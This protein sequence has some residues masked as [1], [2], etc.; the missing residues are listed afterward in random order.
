MHKNV[1]FYYL[2]IMQEVPRMA[3]QPKFNSYSDN[4][5]LIYTC[6]V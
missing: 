3:L 1:M 4:T 5:V 6:T 2:S